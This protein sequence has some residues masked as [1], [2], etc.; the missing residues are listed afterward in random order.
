MQLSKKRNTEIHGISELML[1]F[2]GFTL[3]ST[4]CNISLKRIK[5]KHNSIKNTTEIS[6]REPSKYTWCSEKKA[7]EP[8]TIKLKDTSWFNS[9]STVLVIVL[10]CRE[11]LPHTRV[12]NHLPEDALLLCRREVRQVLGHGAS[13]NLRQLP[14]AHAVE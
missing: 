5:E 2:T 6:K 1:R 12:Y 8:L 10:L 14:G 13:N 3:L 11:N 4:L 9:C 7:V